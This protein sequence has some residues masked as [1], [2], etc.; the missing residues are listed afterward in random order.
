[1]PYRTR[2]VA[3]GAC[4]I[5]TILTVP[6]FPAEDSK[7]RA[8]SLR[9]RRGGNTPNTLEVLQELISDDVD[10]AATRPDRPQSNVPASIDLSL[11]AVLPSRVCAQTEFI[12]SSFE[13]D[14]HAYTKSTNVDLFHCIF[15]EN[16]T[17]PISAYIVS[18]EASSSRT[19]VNHNPLPEMTFEEF[20]VQAEKLITISATQDEQHSRRIWFHFEGRV[21]EITYKCIQ[22]LRKH[23]AL[24]LAKQQL[25]SEL[26]LRISV[27]L[28]KPLRNG[29]RDLV[30]GA[31]YVFYSRSWAEG[32]GYGSAEACLKGEAEQLGQQ[33]VESLLTPDKLL[34][35]TWGAQGA[36]SLMS[37]CWIDSALSRLQDYHVSKSPAYVTHDLDQVVIGTTGAGDAFIAGALFGLIRREMEWHCGLGVQKG[38]WSVEQTLKFANGVAGRKIL[39]QGFG[40]LGAATRQ[41]RNALDLQS[42]TNS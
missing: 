13:M 12:A 39:Q 4:A 10:D 7:L 16:Y 36:C 2:L 27:E 37:E 35:C 6:H 19:I 20:V 22:Y 31:D 30:L 25:G 28:E 42:A 34:I 41:L 17:E 21:P 14:A 18:S 8:T 38:G 40:G 5:D 33:R 29:L 15:R 1:M 11:M 23:P 24:Q 32:E 3:V 9:K 26:I